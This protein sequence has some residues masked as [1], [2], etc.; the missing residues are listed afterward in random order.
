ML[1]WIH[2]HVSGFGTDY[3]TPDGTAVRDYVHVTDLAQA[4][5]LAI[6][7]LLGGG[8]TIAVNL[9]SGRGASVLEVIETARSITGA[10]IKASASPRRAGDPP[11]LV[12]DA[13]QAK[14]LLGWVPNRSDLT[15]IINDAWRWHRARFGH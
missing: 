12:A 15:T 4:H 1:H 7:H 9:A 3:A 13:S 8:D 6:E 2:K 5:A 10:N 11:I 14:S